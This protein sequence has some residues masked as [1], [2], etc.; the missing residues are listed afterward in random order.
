MISVALCTYNGAKYIDQQLQSIAN[1]SRLPDE[2]IIYDDGST[3]N[4]NSILQEWVVK[5]KNLG[6]HVILNTNTI[7]L[8]TVKNFEQ[9]ILSCSGDWIFLCDQDDVWHN[10]KVERMIEAAN[11]N[12]LALFS[13]AMLINEAGIS[14]NRTLWDYWNF[15]FE[16]KKRWS[17][18][19]FAFMDLLYNRNFVT[20]ATL[21]LNRRLLSK[22]LPINVPNSYYHDAWFALHASARS[23]LQFMEDITISYRV[24]DKQQVGITHGGKDLRS[25]LS[26]QNISTIDFQINMLKQYPFIF[27]SKPYLL[28]GILGKILMRDAR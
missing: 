25:V 22:S 18:N 3:D 23:G 17:N 16:N 26:E 11:S 13:N 15:N 4:T 19:K 14:L 8:K 2:I 28:K 9:A 10:Q 20:G 24:H 6:I 7:T 5:F 27:L 12:T 21:M 1:Q